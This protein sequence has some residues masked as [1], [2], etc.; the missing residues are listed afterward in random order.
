MDIIQVAVVTCYGPAKR[1][2]HFTTLWDRVVRCCEGAGQTSAT[3]YSIQKLLQQKL[4]ISKLDPTTS[5]NSQHAA[6]RCYRVAKHVQ[7]V[8]CNTVARCCVEMFY[9]F[10]WAFISLKGQR[11]M[12]ALVNYFM[13][14]TLAFTDFVTSYRILGLFLSGQ[15]PKIKNLFVNKRCCLR[16]VWWRLKFL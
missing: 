3:S 7:C 8:A 2:Q 15:T 11:S 13:L 1:T 5:N 12:F 10:G 9:A 6:T 14:F 16:P 4:T